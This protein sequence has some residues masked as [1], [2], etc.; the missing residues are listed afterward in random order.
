ME[1][2]LLYWILSWMDVQAGSLLEGCAYDT[3]YNFYDVSYASRYVA[4][5]IF[6]VSHLKILELCGN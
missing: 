2:L 5:R 3:C 4:A 1:Y 6:R